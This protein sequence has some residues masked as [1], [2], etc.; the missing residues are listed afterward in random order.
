MKMKH[1]LLTLSLALVM[2]SGF[3][4]NTV[5]TEDNAQGIVQMS[6]YMADKAAL[7]AEKQLDRQLLKAEKHQYRAE[8][9]AAW[10]YKVINKQM[11]K[12]KNKA[13]GGLDDPVDKFFWYWLIGWG[14]GLVLTIIASAVAVGSIYSGGFG[15]AVIFGILGWI[16][17]VG[18]TVCGIIWLVKK[19][20]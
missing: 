20:G 11:A 18:G 5:N 6:D 1:L 12:S 17:W 2:S 9:R 7:K 8:K 14:A 4:G 13:L 16:C 15:A 3:A 19:L 10:F